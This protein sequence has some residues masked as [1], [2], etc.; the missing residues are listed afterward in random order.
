MCKAVH[1]NFSPILSAPE[2]KS[3]EAL[4]VKEK[5]YIARGADFMKMG[6]A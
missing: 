1:I 3:V 5:G 2:G 6:S 4:N